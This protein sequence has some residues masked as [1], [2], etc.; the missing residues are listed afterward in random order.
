MSL[1]AGR[2]VHT[3]AQCQLNEMIEET[4]FGLGL[5]LGVYLT[6]NRHLSSNLPMA[7]PHQLIDPWTG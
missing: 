4:H 6:Y 1:R 3:R 5:E 7:V 2:S